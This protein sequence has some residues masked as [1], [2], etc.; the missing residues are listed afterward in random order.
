M[1]TLR[2]PRVALGWMVFLLIAVAGLFYVKWFPYYN[3]A[4]V[5]ASQHSIGKSILMGASATAPEPSWQAALDY[6]M[7]YGKAIWQAMVLGLLLGSAVQA[8]IPPRWV[9]RALGEHNFGSVV[10]GGL[11]SLPGMMCT[12]C[13][14]PVVAGLRARQAAPGAAIAFWLGNTVLNPAALVF[15]GFVLGWQWTGLRLV[16][17]MLMVFG[18]GYAV[19]RMVTPAQAAA[20]REALSKLVQEDDPG[21]AFS[22]WLKI[23][24]RM[25]LRLV[26]EYI[27]L[28]LLLGAARAWLF[29]HIGPDIGNAALWIIAFAVAGTLF[30]IPT[31]GEVPIIQAMLSL[32]MATGPAG[33]LLM[34]L[35][36]VSVPSLVMLGRSFPPKVLA[37]VAASVVAFGVIGG[38]VAGWLF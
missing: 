5:A 23:L 15:M 37:F 34:T 13:A 30:V 24:G 31:A 26:P 8:L 21:T 4:F 1:T 14:A 18:L 17:G 7:A 3:R 36:P 19:N 6:A 16:L 32:G 33:A 28:V 29:P 10:N 9:A 38:V 22:R 2:Q 20:S 12:C 11:M 35:P 27:V 25:T